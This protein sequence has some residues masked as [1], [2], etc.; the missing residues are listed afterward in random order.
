MRMQRVSL[1]LL[2]DLCLPVVVL[3]LCLSNFSAH[4]SSR[5]KMQRNHNSRQ[6]WFIY[7]VV[8]T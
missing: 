6:Y 5:E 3:S 8:H 7:Q 1:A 4:K 2:L